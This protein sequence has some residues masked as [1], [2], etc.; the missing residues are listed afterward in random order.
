MC[1]KTISL[2][3]GTRNNCCARLILRRI[4][5]DVAVEQ[6]VGG[7]F[8]ELLLVLSTHRPDVKVV[9]PNI[10]NT[11]AIGRKFGIDAGIGPPK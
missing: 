1:R 4:P 6:V 3:S 7:I 2:L 5:I 9:L 10:G 11:T 8:G